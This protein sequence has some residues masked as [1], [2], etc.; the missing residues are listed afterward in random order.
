MG[1]LSCVS[2][3]SRSAIF[4]CYGAELNILWG[5]GMFGS[6]ISGNNNTFLTLLFTFMVE[7]L[8]TEQK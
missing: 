3:I 8:N 2:E 1:K 4:L 7:F 6:Y 5:S